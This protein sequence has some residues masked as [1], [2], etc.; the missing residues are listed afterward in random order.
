ME[1]RIAWHNIFGRNFP[2]TTILRS[3]AIGSGF[4][5]LD[6]ITMQSRGGSSVFIYNVELFKTS[7]F[8]KKASGMLQKIYIGTDTIR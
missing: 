3:W 8:N 5:L 2:L 7:R 4:E 1:S 6:V